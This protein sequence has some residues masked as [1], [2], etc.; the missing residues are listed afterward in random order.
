MS[1]T[2]WSLAF[3]SSTLYIRYKNLNQSWIQ[4]VNPSVLMNY[5]KTH[6]LKN[7]TEHRN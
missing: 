6:F 3:H 2:E 4:P 1:Y 5:S 7:E